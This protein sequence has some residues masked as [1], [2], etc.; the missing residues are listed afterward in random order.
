MNFTIPTPPAEALSQEAVEA[1]L[2]SAL[3]GDMETKHLHDFSIGELTIMVDRFTVTPPTVKLEGRA[4]A[5]EFKAARAA[6]RKPV[7]DRKGEPTTITIVQTDQETWGFRCGFAAA[8]FA[9]MIRAANTDPQEELR[10]AKM[11]MDQL[12]QLPPPQT[13]IR[14]L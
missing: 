2:R 13:E 10:L 7:W 5:E 9:Q 4:A 3:E 14:K 1:L 11:A 6:G 12:N 8:D